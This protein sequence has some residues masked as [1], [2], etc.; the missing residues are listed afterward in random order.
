MTIITKPKL[1]LK[2]T[3]QTMVGFDN[4]N[5]NEDDDENQFSYG[6]RYVSQ[7]LANGKIIRE[8]APLTLY[9]I[10]HPQVGDFR[11]HSQDHELFCE[12]LSTVFKAQLRDDPTAV[13]LHDVRVAWATPNVEPHGPDIAVIF[14]VRT[15][16][17]WSTFD[18]VEEGTRPTLIVEITS[19]RTRQI[20]L[21]N[22]YTEYA[23]VG[24]PYYIIVD[25]PKRHDPHSRRLIGYELSDQNYVSMRSNNQG[26]LWLPPVQIWLGIQ[27]TKLCCYDQ[28][29]QVIGDYTAITVKY[30]QAEARAEAE[31]KAKIEAE[32]RAEAE[33]KAKIEAEARATEAE[34][35]LKEVEAELRRL[36]GEG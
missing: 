29:G 13:V 9:D 5:P 31:I 12:Y 28:T 2:L 22:K 25:T 36:R 30:H 16:K 17:N 27:G 10:L 3:T 19:P 1:S 7:T 26:W 11:V 35:R 34:A 32:A 20:D 6:W 23:Q 18:E 14:G 33:T 8:R 4:I 21:S 15:R 24:I